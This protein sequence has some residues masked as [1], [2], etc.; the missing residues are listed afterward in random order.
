VRTLHEVMAPF[1]LSFCGVAATFAIGFE[2]SCG[3]ASESC[4]EWHEQHEYVASRVELLQ[5]QKLRSLGRNDAAYDVKQVVEEGC[6]E[7]ECVQSSLGCNLRCDS[8]DCPN[9]SW[10]L[11]DELRTVTTSPRLFGVAR[12]D[13]AGMVVLATMF[14][15]ASAER[16]GMQFGGVIDPLCKSWITHDAD[17]S[18]VLEALFGKDV[19]VKEVPKSRSCYVEGQLEHLKH[20]VMTEVFGDRSNVILA[21]NFRH[22]E[23]NS[24]LF[25]ECIT[26]SFL[27]SWRST[28]GL[29]REQGAHFFSGTRPTIAV[30]V[31]RGDILQEQDQNEDTPHLKRWKADEDFLR[32]IKLVLERIPTAEV[33]VFGTTGEQSPAIWNPYLEKGYTVHAD[34]AILEDWSHMSQADVLIMSPSSFSIVAGITNPNCV[35]YSDYETGPSHDWFL[36]DDVSRPSYGAELDECIERAAVRRTKMA[37]SG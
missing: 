24:F 19:I 3:N 28:S 21:D 2:T 14:A 22:D 36:A 31:R 15:M 27:S 10:K 13:G 29:M 4:V 1:F 35:M 32:Q 34:G 33:H 12:C 8:T 6:A 20:A 25:K 23:Y 5:M 37:S 11:E 30:H 9:R 17:T 26:D 16:F 7:D 18:V